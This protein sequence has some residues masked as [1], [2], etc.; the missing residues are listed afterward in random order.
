VHTR[1]GKNE[2]KK[3]KKA[4]TKMNSKL[5]HEAWVLKGKNL[6]NLSRYCLILPKITQLAKTYATPLSSALLYAK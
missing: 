5:L 1:K 3:I 6:Q 2:T 4:H